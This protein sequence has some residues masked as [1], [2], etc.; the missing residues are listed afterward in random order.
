MRHRAVSSRW[1]ALPLALAALG[2]GEDEK[3]GSVMLAIS[4][5]LFIDK[6]VSRVDVIIQPEHGPTQSAPFNLFPALDGQF[7][8]GTFAIIEGSS[9][10][11]FVRVRI[12][13]RKENAVRVV[14]EAAL[15]VPRSRTA[16]LSM[17]IQWLCNGHVQEE[18]QQLW[19]SSCD[20][21]QTCKRGACESDAV[22]EAALPDYVPADVFGGGTPTG[23]GS[24]FDTVPC[25]EHNTEATLDTT[26]CVLDTEVTDDLNIAIRLPPGG[27]GHCT[28]AECWIPLDASAD[29]GWA[30]IEGGARVQLPAAVCQH[31]ADGASVRV[32]HECPSKAPATPTCGPWTLVGTEPGGD[33]NLDGAPLVVTN[34]TLSEELE[35]AS[36]RLARSVASACAAITQAS[37]PAEPTP[38]DLSQLCRAAS[39]AL[40]ALA[41]L[42]WYHVTT[43]CWPD[44]SRQ[45]DCERAC[46]E[47]CDPGTLE[48]RCNPSTITGKC[49]DVCNSRVCLGSQTQPV[50]C[51]GGCDGT[52][53][54]SCD[55][56]CVGQCDGVC[57]TAGADGYCAGQCVGACVGL[58]QGRCEG[59]CQGTCEGDPN[60]PVAA[61]TSGTECRGGCAGAYTSPV[62]HSPLT[63]SP[64]DLDQDCEADCRAVGT[65]GVACEPSTAWV[66]PRTG[67]DPTL[68]AAIDEALADLIPVRDIE[69]AA[70]LDEASRISMRLQATAATSGDPIGS[71]NALV[72]VRKAAELL[73][74]AGTAADQAL[75]AAGAPRDTPGGA[76]PSARCDPSVASG[77]TPLIDDFEDG[78]A[79]VLPQEGRDGDWHLV[80]DNSA[81]GR[82]SLS[83][84]PVPDNNGAHQSNHAMHLTGSNF[85]EWGAGF[86]VDLRDSSLPYDASAYAGMKFWARGE[87]SLRLILV[88]Q[89]LATGHVCATCPAAS[90][91]CSLFYNTQISLTDTWTE[92]TIPWG[93]LSQ[94]SVGATPFAPDQLMQL[95]FEAPASDQFELWLDD[96]S[97]Y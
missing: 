21:G 24:C 12:I 37:P 78:D 4:T 23:G 53:S 20:E 86:S 66:E 8:P 49:D 69:A 60:L 31:V 5:D 87:P 28:N 22:D 75:D 84:P 9:P 36:D 46:D 88:Q 67:L 15:N 61:C 1:V 2:C 77:S 33:G 76:S 70:L 97:F 50:D 39:S 62:C 94:A 6:D 52:C 73:A 59:T 91:D 92:Y 63:E 26:S 11:E 57:A 27:D 7:L 35:T 47:S 10:G 3:L 42:D 65:I 82:L 29:T 44:H 83:E 85:A 17:P 80:R 14:R 51:P 34:K 43:R 18:G 16:L 89:S 58:C 68:R 32:S 81:N 96:V 90:N 55:G 30:S 13:A 54:G 41:P 48:E 40:T 71:V 93:Q 79:H 64:C 45:L 74:A 19:R 72:R 38:A 25:F 56:A 95:M